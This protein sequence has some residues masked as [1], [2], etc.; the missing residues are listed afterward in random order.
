MLSGGTGGRQGSVSERCKGLGDVSVGQ[1]RVATGALMNQFSCGE[2]RMEP[3]RG[4]SVFIAAWSHIGRHEK[5]G[6]LRRKF[7]V[8]SDKQ[9]GERVRYPANRFHTIGPGCTGQ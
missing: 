1:E 7:R 6:Y 4:W 8:E 9:M 3:W 2:L 5:V